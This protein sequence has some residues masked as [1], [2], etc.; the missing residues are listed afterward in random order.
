MKRKLSKA[1]VHF[2][3]LVENKQENMSFKSIRK[4]FTSKAKDD[5][6]DKA[7]ILTDH[8]SSSGS[9]LDEHYYDSKNFL[10]KVEK[11]FSVLIYDFEKGKR[12]ESEVV[13]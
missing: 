7:N 1:F 11:E 2:L 5:Y 4:I 6:G 9:V 3:S 12:K 10:A 8:K 13:A